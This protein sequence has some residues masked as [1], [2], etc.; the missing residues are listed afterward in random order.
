VAHFEWPD[1]GTSA[2]VEDSGADLRLTL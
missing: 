1:M 2:N